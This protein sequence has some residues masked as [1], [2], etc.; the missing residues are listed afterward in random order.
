MPPIQFEP[1]P[2]AHL[3]EDVLDAH[4]LAEYLLT[5][6]KGTVVFSRGGGG[7]L[8]RPLTTDRLADAACAYG[9]VAFDGDL[10]WE[11][12]FDGEAENTVAA[13]TI[14]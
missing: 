11:P 2:E 7:G 9:L 4:T 5:L 13:V 14:G 3:P 12:A 6:P 8:E 10:F 1:N